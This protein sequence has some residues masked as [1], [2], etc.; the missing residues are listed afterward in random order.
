MDAGLKAGFRGKVNVDLPEILHMIYY[1][2]RR[3]GD[4]YS[5]EFEDSCSS[6]A[7]DR[8]GQPNGEDPDLGP[9]EVWR[10]EN[11]GWGVPES[12]IPEPKAWLRGR[13]YVLWDG[14]RA[15]EMGGFRRS[16]RRKKET[17]AIH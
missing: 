13:A 1:G 11:T 16:T 17:N 8:Y 5:Q 3:I 14:D 7:L 4:G 6:V 15:R 2:A 12:F 10:T 9:Y